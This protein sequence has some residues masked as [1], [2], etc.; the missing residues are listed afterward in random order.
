MPSIKELEAF[1]ATVEAGSFEGAAR[2]LNAT[3]PAI[4]KRISELESELGVRLFDRSTRHCQITLRGRALIPFAQRVLGEIGEIR[5]VVADRSSLAGHIRLGV[6]E[7]IAFTQLVEVLRKASD[8]LPKLV[9]DVEIGVSTDLIRRV[10][11]RELDIACVVGPVLEPDLVSEPFWEVPLSWIARGQPWSEKPLTIEE[12]AERTLLLP[13]GGRHIPTIEGWF[14]SRGLRAEH[15]IICNSLS[16]ALKMTAI[17]M[18]ISLMPIEC[19]R[20][21]LDAGIIS[22]VP[23]RIKLPSNVFVTTY[24]SGQLEPA[25]HA[26]IDILREL[27]ATLKADGPGI[28]SPA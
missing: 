13:V 27:A 19:A 20:Q 1:V 28:K 15:I 12:L 7:T 3:A 18:G 5:R 8:D 4:S 11:T 14:K 26:F 23:V 2:R 24:P 25:L 16:T 10:A 17:G 22:P 21:E 9:I 6:P